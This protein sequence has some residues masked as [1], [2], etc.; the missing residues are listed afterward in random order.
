MA[1]TVKAAE[2]AKKR[3]EILATAQRLVFDKGYE[4]MTIQD[5]VAALGISSGAF[6]HYFASKQ[7]VLE[8]LAEQMQDEIEQQV[9]ALA[10][11]QRLAPD[12]QLK[13]C[14]AA[15]LRRDLS[16]PAHAWLTALLRV[17]FTD[18]NALIR[19]KV[20]EARLRRLGPLLTEVM[21]AGV[22][23][24]VFTPTEPALAAEV[25]L[26]LIQGLQYALARRYAVYAHDADGPRFIAASV[27]AYNAYLGAV[28]R[29]LGLPPEFLYRLD[30]AVVRE[31]LVIEAALKARTADPHAAPAA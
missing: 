13:Q 11:N 14:L 6:Y 3:A 19:H 25:M 28:E 4:R 10:H 17:W 2:Y 7:A 5:L 26:A 9:A 18:D 21:Q 22:Q 8:A 20:D 23:A 15:I 30:V 24:G 1:R 16:P 27:A 12:E 31:S 29:L